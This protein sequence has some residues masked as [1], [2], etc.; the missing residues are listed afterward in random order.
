MK[1]KISIHDGQYAYDV[2][3]LLSFNSGLVFAFVNAPIKY[4]CSVCE[5]CDI[6]RVL[7]APIDEVNEPVR[8]IND[9]WAACH[10]CAEYCSQDYLVKIIHE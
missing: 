5:L 9:Y 2:D 10:Y 3:Q 7:H 6:N 4:R 8:N 1:N